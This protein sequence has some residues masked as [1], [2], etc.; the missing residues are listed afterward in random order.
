MSAA[1]ALAVVGRATPR[2]VRDSVL[3]LAH[4]VEAKDRMAAMVAMAEL[5]QPGMVPDLV[6]ALADGDEGV[7]GAAH[8]ALVQVT[9]QDFGM[10]ARPWLKWWDGN[11]NKHRVEWL[12]EAL[13]HDVSEIRKGS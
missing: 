9:R 6:R 10:D 13:N 11:Q 7:V 3:G 12:I 2:E 8:A 5:R 4:A 1:L